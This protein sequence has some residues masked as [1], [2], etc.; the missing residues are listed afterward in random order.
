MNFA[1]QQDG[2]AER[3]MQ[4]FARGDRRAREIRVADDVGNPGRLAARSRRAPAGPRRGAN[5]ISRLTRRTRE[6]AAGRA[7]DVDAAQHVRLAIDAPERAVF[8][9]ERFADGLQDLRRRLGKGGRLDQRARRDVLGGQL[10]VGPGIDLG[11]VGRESHSGR[12][13]YIFRRT[14]EGERRGARKRRYR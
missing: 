9:A 11:G 8:P 5:V 3:R 12:R 2:K 10:P 7:P 6:T 1:A 13:D 14:R 4:S